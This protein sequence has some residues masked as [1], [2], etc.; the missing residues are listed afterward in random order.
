MEQLVLLKPKTR[1]GIIGAGNVGS[2]ISTWFSSYGL[3][4]SHEV[5]IG[6]VDP[7]KTEAVERIYKKFGVRGA[8]LQEIVQTSNIVFLTVPHSVI[9]D[10]IRNVAPSMQSGAALVEG[11]SIKLGKEVRPAETMYNFPRKDLEYISIHTLDRGE[12]SL[13]DKKV[14]VIP[15]RPIHG[16]YWS[17][18]LKEIIEK[19]HGI[20]I[21]YDPLAHDAFV[22][23]Y[24]QGGPH[25]VATEFLYLLLKEKV[26]PG[27]LNRVETGFFRGFF[28]YMLRP[29]SGN[30]ELY[31]DIQDQNSNLVFFLERLVEG[32]KNRIKL[33]KA[34]DKQALLK[35]FLEIQEYFGKYV[36]EASKRIDKKIGY[37]LGLHIY[38]REPER[39]SLEERL[40]M[41]IEGDDSFIEN[42]RVKKTDPVFVEKIAEA[43]IPRAKYYDITI[44]NS[45][46][47]ANSF[48]F[49]IKR[50]EKTD[51]NFQLKQT[52]ILFV[53]YEK[54]INGTLPSPL[55]TLPKR[56][57]RN[58]FPQHL[59][60]NMFD[61]YDV[62]P[63]STEWGPLIVQRWFWN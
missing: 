46:Y 8:G 56:Y 20:V 54:E 52:K 31:I 50:L 63:E 29:F 6:D 35:Q 41:K 3:R 37:P 58:R 47:N 34:R 62:Q 27:E 49:V 55:K 39:A 51:D 42:I 57:L 19:N 14:I 44:P 59:I 23:T 28:D 12:G 4:N 45:G 25:S 1:V 60:L 61:T 36:F 13:K 40:Q 17:E 24:V 26:S 48:V 5:L 30:A 18:Y 21:P 2:S 32:I 38:F 11:S 10:T 15:V 53:P 16:S 9:D 33:L 22:G 7:A 43:G